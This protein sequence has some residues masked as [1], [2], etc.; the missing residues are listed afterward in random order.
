M[1]TCFALALLAG[2]LIAAPASA[3]TDRKVGITLGYP[4][5]VG[6]LWHVTGRFSLRPEIGW[7]F[8]TTESE[9]DF[10][11]GTGLPPRTSTIEGDNWLATIGL[12]VPF[13]VKSWDALRV[14][15]V[16]S[17]RYTQQTSTSVSSFFVGGALP[18]ISTRET[19]T[20]E[21]SGGAAFGVQFTPHQRFAIF[22]ETGLQYTSA[23]T[24]DADR[25]RL[26]AFGTEGVLGAVFYF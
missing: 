3:Q 16:P 17:Y 11:S 24:R 7:S 5:R 25:F 23:G 14:T 9:I 15:L 2:L 13:T 20:Y 22:G 10:T 26:R 1:R 4:A 6:V 19:I 12:S 18:T 8:G 21:H